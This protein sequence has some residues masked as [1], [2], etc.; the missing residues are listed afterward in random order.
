M[1]ETASRQLPSLTIFEIFPP[2]LAPLIS[3][4][5]IV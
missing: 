4:Q 3:H 1:Y 5:L 2:Y